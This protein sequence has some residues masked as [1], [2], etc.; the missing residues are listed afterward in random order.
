VNETLRGKSS[1]RLASWLAVFAVVGVTL[2]AAQARAATDPREIAAREAFVA[3]RYQQA[4]DL[5]AKL[6]AETL[7][8]NYLRN[9]GR[10][11]QNLGEPDRAINSF[12]DY[13]RKAK[14]L[15]ADERGEIDGYIRDME[16]LKR[17]HESEAT[18]AS[19]KPTPTANPPPPVQPLALAAPPPSKSDTNVSVVVSTS[20]P[21]AAAESPP[22]YSRWWFWAAVIGVA[23]AGVGIAAAAG[24]FTHTQD[25]TCPMGVSCGP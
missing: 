23:A 22:I 11:Y 3:G 24:A 13:L 19:A 9:I 21:P 17:Q 2:L 4:L 16:E 6:Y 12:R 15:T 8:P 20:P 7:H 10:C 14:G 18:S 5:F 1:R 25:A